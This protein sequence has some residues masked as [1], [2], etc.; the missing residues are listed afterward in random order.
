MNDITAKD[1]IQRDLQGD[2]LDDNHATRRYFR[3]WLDGSYNGEE[4]YRF[5]V[6]CL[7]LSHDKPSAL[8]SF[9]IQEFCSYTARDAN[10]SDGY[11][12][13]V[14]VATLDKDTLAKLTAALTEDALDLI[15][16]WLEEKEAA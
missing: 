9:V 5:N 15:A 12:Q 4:S 16:D 8:R 3:C 2:L 6:E 13:K 11:A 7:K 10:C 14:I 1:R